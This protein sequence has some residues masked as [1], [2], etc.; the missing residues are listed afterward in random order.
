MAVVASTKFDQAGGASAVAGRALRGVLDGTANDVVTVTN[1]DNTDVNSWEMELLYVPPTSGVALGVFASGVSPTP[2]GVFTPD[3]PGCY[4]V[5]LTVRDISAFPD[6]DIR[7]FAIANFRGHVTPPY[8]KNPDPI[9]L[10][11]KAD[12]LNFSAQ[13]FGWAGDRL[14]GLFESYF[15]TFEDKFPQTVT[16][17][18][19]TA[20]ADHSDPANFPA[21]LWLVDTTTIAGAS[22]FNLPSGA[23]DGQ[24]FAVKDN[25][26]DAFNNPITL[27]LP[28]GDQFEDATTERVIFA[29]GGRIVIMKLTGVSWRILENTNREEWIDLFAGQDSTSNNG[30]TRV[31]SKNFDPDLFPLS[32]RFVL[33]AIMETTDAG[34]THEVQ[35]FN[36]TLA[37][38]V[39]TPIGSVS[40]TPELNAD[41]LV[42][43]G[44]LA[45][46]SN[47][48]ELQHRMASGSGPDE[49][50]ISSAHLRVVYSLTG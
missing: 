39:S 47:V 32:A 27:T 21:N 10:D 12:E 45:A 19:F 15:D 28:G 11:L 44:D 3:V 49:V 6:V 7:N 5:Q 33:E 17:T 34:N 30:F 41:T 9:D 20:A 22:V 14:E 31:A 48:Y 42:S 18:P 25:Q 37:A 35:L 24:V 43:P 4:R 2:S 46:G 38:A 36:I 16:A 8:Q 1:G 29:N 40:L 26:N 13:V 50:T 23:R